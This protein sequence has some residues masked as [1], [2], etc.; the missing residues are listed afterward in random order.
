[1]FQI[2]FLIASYRCSTVKLPV[3]WLARSAALTAARMQQIIWLSQSEKIAGALN[4]DT[5]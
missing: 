1:M 2:V 5:I 3:P 4:L